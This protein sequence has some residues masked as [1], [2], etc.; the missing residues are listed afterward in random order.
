MKR[1]FLFAFGTLASFGIA[2]PAYS[3]YPVIYNGTENDQTIVV[4]CKIKKPEEKYK[5]VSKPTLIKAKE[6]QAFDK[7]TFEDQAPLC[8]MLDEGNAEVSLYSISVPIKGYSSIPPSSFVIPLEEGKI[9]N[10]DLK[11]A[12]FSSK[13]SIKYSRKHGSMALFFQ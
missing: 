9:N 12:L 1:N 8:G 4:T 2:I 3:Q 7:S 6:S 5:I 13:L 11:G 10:N